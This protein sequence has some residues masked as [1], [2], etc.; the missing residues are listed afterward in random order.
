[1]FQFQ[2]FAPALYL[3]THIPTSTDPH[4]STS[5]HHHNGTRTQYTSGIEMH[6]WDICPPLDACEVRARAASKHRTQNVTP[7]ALGK[8]RGIREQFASL[9]LPPV[10]VRCK[11]CFMCHKLS[12]PVPGVLLAVVALRYAGVSL[13]TLL[14][15]DNQTSSTL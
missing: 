2:T 5:A 4:N 13:V 8:S 1:M 11:L 12:G 6:R 7:H 9:E 3:A 15:V 14:S 10:P